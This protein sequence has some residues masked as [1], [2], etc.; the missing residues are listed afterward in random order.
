MANKIPATKTT[1]ENVNVGK[2]SLFKKG[3][4]E[5]YS[6][7]LISYKTKY[8]LINKTKEE[9]AIVQQIVESWNPTTKKYDKTKVD[10][11]ISGQETKY[12][13]ARNKI[14]IAVSLDKEFMYNKFSML[15]G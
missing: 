1:Y 10:R 13:I 8:R 12:V 11:T 4:L 5:F 2:V 15:R 7:E 6:I 14:T 9:Y 3:A